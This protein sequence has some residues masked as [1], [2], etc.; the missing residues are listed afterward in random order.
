MAV[1]VG[2]V[3]GA[4]AAIATER[5]E[6]ILLERTFLASV[7][8]GDATPDLG[9]S[10][11]AGFLVGAEDVVELRLR[12]IEAEPA[13]E[14]WLV[15]AIVLRDPRIAVGFVGFHAAPDARGMVEIGYEV[16]PAFRRRG[17]ASEAAIALR[18]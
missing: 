6:L 12:Q 16:L 4:A 17:Y 2:G 10:D 1:E 11:P 13:I 18:T 3:V 15:R 9:F 8:G 7:L 14:P 5:L